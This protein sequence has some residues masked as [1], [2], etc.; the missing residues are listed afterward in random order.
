M[1]YQKAL[2]L[3]VSTIEER[4]ELF[5]RGFQTWYQSLLE[6]GLDAHICIAAEGYDPSAALE[7]LA[8]R[9]V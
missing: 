1:E 7:Q 5:L 6:S 8:P 2:I 9:D 3:A 4:H